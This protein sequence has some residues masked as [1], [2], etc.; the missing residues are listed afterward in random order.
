MDAQILLHEGEATKTVSKGVVN[1]FKQFR[2]L[3]RQQA[4]AARDK[5]VTLKSLKDFAKNFKLSTAMPQ[6]LIPIIAKD[7]KKQEEILTENQANQLRGA[8]L[9]EGKKKTINNRLDL[10][11]IFNS[12][13]EAASIAPAFSRR[14]N[15]WE[16]LDLDMSVAPQGFQ[17]GPPVHTQ[18]QDNAL[19]GNPKPRDSHGPQGML[20]GPRMPTGYSVLPGLNGQNATTKKAM[21]YAE[22]TKGR[23]SQ[24]FTPPNTPSINNRL[25]EKKTETRETSTFFRPPPRKSKAIVIKRSDGEVVQ[26]NKKNL[27]SSSQKLISRPVVRLP[28]SKTTGEGDRSQE[29][30]A[31]LEGPSKFEDPHQSEFFHSKGLPHQTFHPKAPIPGQLSKLIDPKNFSALSAVGGLEGLERGLVMN[32]T[33]NPRRVDP[34]PPQAFPPYV[35]QGVPT[36][37]SATSQDGTKLHSKSSARKLNYEEEWEYQD[38]TVPSVQAAGKNEP[39]T[40]PLSSPL[41]ETHTPSP[42]TQRRSDNLYQYTDSSTIFT[43][44]PHT[45]W[46]SYQQS[47]MATSISKQSLTS[48]TK[49]LG[50]PAQIEEVPEPVL[51]GSQAAVADEDG[52]QSPEFTNHELNDSYSVL[53]EDS[54][55]VLDQSQRQKVIESFAESL[56]KN[57]QQECA[58]AY[59]FK[60]PPLSLQHDLQG[61]IKDF[62]DSVKGDTHQRSRRQ[63][64]KA[65]RML[66]SDIVKKLASVLDTK[67]VTEGSRIY[68]EIAKQAERAYLPQKSFAE[69]IGDWSVSMPDPLICEDAVLLA[70]SSSHDQAKSQSADLNNV[71]S[72]GEGDSG[73]DSAPP[74]SVGTTTSVGLLNINSDEERDIYEWL[75]THSAFKALVAKLVGV[76]QRACPDQMVFVQ[77]QILRAMRRP[78]YQQKEAN[79]ER[80]ALIRIDWDILQ[81][82]REQYACG[83]EQDLGGVLAI[84]GKAADA[85]LNTVRSYFERN[86]DFE[87]LVLLDTIKASIKAQ[88]RRGHPNGLRPHFYFPVDQI[89]NRRLAL[90]ISPALARGPIHAD[91]ESGIFSVT[92][93]EHFIVIVAQQLAWLGAA[94]RASSGGL[95]YCYVHFKVL[96]PSEHP[97]SDRPM[98]EITYDVA[99]VPANEQGSCWN[100]FAGDCVIVHGFHIS[101]RHHEESGLEAP[102][103]ML[104]KL[105]GAP[106]AVEYNKG[107][108]FKG[109]SIILAPFKRNGQSPVTIQWHLVEKKGARLRL[110]DID[111]LCPVPRLTAEEL[112]DN[113]LHSPATRSFL[114][115]CPKSVNILGKSLCKFSCLLTTLARMYSNNTPPATSQM[116]HTKTGYTKLPKLSRTVVSLTGASI[117]FNYFASG[118]ATFA[119][120][121][122][123]GIHHA[124]NPGFYEDLL[125]D[126]KQIHVILQDMKDRR[127]WHTD[128]ER[129]ILNLILQ[130][131]AQ[132]PFTNGERKVFLQAADM[133]LPESV[134]NSM[135]EN[136]NVVLKLDQHL[137]KAVVNK[138]YFRD[139]VHE[140]YGVLEGLEAHIELVKKAGVE[141]KLDWRKRIQGW[142]YLS[143]VNRSRTFIWKEAELKRTCGQWPEFARDIDAVVLFGNGFGEIFRPHPDIHMCQAIR[144]VPVQKDYLTIEADS[145]H[146]LYVENG[147]GRDQDRLTSSGLRWHRATDLFEP[148]RHPNRRKGNFRFCNCDRVQQLVPRGA[149]GKIR[150]PGNFKR[151]GAIIFGQGN[152][153]WTKDIFRALHSQAEAAIP[154]PSYSNSYHTSNTCLQVPGSNGKEAMRTIAESQRS[155]LDSI[156]SVSTD[157]RSTS[158]TAATSSSYRTAAT[159]VSTIFEQSCAQKGKMNP[160]VW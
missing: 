140:L 24:P 127:A 110:K 114:G 150:S 91:L 113:V 64:A 39:K 116:D 38:V 72:L 20:R 13:L 4:A 49:V 37:R 107:L 105:A 32:I 153:T 54:V 148:C 94:C 9:R 144:V 141:L 62:S 71:E 87:Q 130:Q 118:G 11:T 83:L 43:G 10:P 50:I 82:L 138:K 35:D 60:N 160:G 124:S 104:A 102:I 133:A 63:G 16:K 111:S 123:D 23:S 27:S 34:S 77:R 146:A 99:R 142:E 58:F 95:A 158:R 98:F 3:E 89:A 125:D 65:I 42:T 131:H 151:S 152:T 22:A 157:T 52:P 126:S 25:P 79:S 106:L 73:A 41:F 21:S 101:P 149:Y 156:E 40:A 59:K 57:I 30:G 1:A 100:Y 6:D 93:T 96:D 122:K 145:L 69:K 115:W 14:R 139:L 137:E 84:T 75:T 68:P 7:K 143:M 86:W 136:S 74:T 70:K 119:L 109:R 56:F 112:G 44:P 46:S 85:Q 120:G 2:A 80:K 26:Y 33:E 17:K 97:E 103:E 18:P 76:I 81:F 128:G 117:G 45:V 12:Q 78:I 67:S 31:I 47:T 51:P 19:L 134:R 108:V 29:F 66:R 88:S 129:L 15:A 132:S 28:P 147:S 5:A 155:H 61:L 53:S 48:R 90:D 8:I 55:V 36:S 92:G 154:R 121:K 135:L 159:S